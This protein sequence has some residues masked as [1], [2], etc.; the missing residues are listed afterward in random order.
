MN[1]PSLNGISQ[2]SKNGN[3][4]VKDS[5][6]NVRD[7]FRILRSNLLP[8][9]L[10]TLAVIF[11]TIL[12]VINAKDIYK[13]STT[14][15]IN[16]PQ[17]SVLTSSLIPEFQDFITDRYI[18]NEIEVLKSYRIRELVAQNLLDT[19]FAV[20]DKDKFYYVFN[21]GSQDDPALVTKSVLCDILPNI[22][23]IEQKKGSM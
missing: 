1:K 16:R 4:D 19:F 2:F 21:H 15:K 11:I 17:G 18:S 7:Y 14:I 22:T 9:L 20:Q 23:K 3:H 5:K 13:S 10:I 12:Y 6:D 8:I